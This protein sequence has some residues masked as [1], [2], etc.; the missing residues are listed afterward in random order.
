MKKDKILISV[1]F[2]FLIIFI[3]ILANISYGG[4]LTKIDLSINTFI[5]AIQNNFFTSITKIIAYGFDT[6]SLFIITIILSLILWFKSDKKL[7]L[8]FS[9]VMAA[10]SLLILILK[11]LIQRA[12]PI[13][14]LMIDN[15]FAFPSGHSVSTVVFFG[16]L[17]FL[18]FKKSK[19][20]LLR[21]IAIIV[22]AF[23]IL[24]IGFSRI[25]LNVHWFS[26]VIGGF[27][28]GLSLLSGSILINR[29]INKRIVR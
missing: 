14:A 13:N 3:L 5:P 29:I 10:D 9:G 12:R 26:D 11:N 16:L 23:M 20:S 1:S 19:S 15:S 8:F 22:S 25:Y 27:A 21:Y 2:L 28:V 24:L 7:A 6:I 18:V 17:T 4:F